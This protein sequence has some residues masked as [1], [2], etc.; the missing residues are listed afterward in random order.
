MQITPGNIM[1]I[2][3]ILLLFSVLAGRIGT[4]YGV[5]VLVLF[6][7]IGMAAG[8]D[9]FGIQ[10]D[11]AAVAELIG[12]FSLCI[13]LFSGG[14]DT[15]FKKV[16]P[17]MGPGLVLATF[18]VLLTTALTGVF[19]HEMMR[20]LLPEYAF[21]WIESF[22]LAAIMSSTDSASVFSILN[23]SG[24]GLKQRLKP[25]LELE[26]GSNDP[27]AYLMVILFISII[28]DGTTLSGG[29]I[30]KTSLEL[31]LQL[32]IGI[33]AGFIIGKVTV[34]LVN[35]LKS[36]NEFLY[37]VMVIACCF[38]AF[39]LTGLI[40]GNSYLAVY[41]AGLVVGNNKLALKRTI[42]TFFGGFTWLVQI[43]MFLTLGLLVNPHELLNI[44][45]PGLLLGIF[46]I[47]VS[48]PVS[49]YL[50]LAPFKRYT[51]KAK[52]YIGWVGLRGA[53]PIIFA[54]YA[55]M[56]PEVTHARFMFNLVFFITLL[57]LLIQG[58]T[59]NSMAKWFGLTE[60][61]PTRH[62]DFELPEEITAVTKEMT[63]TAEHLSEG[64]RLCEM[65]IPDETLVILIKRDDTYLVPKG[66]TR[67]YI[68]DT[69]L[70]L[71]RENEPLKK[72]LDRHCNC[73]SETS[74]AS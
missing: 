15:D 14:L 52:T 74:T 1:L 64:S 59:V 47:L 58:T 26:S 54:T 21:G 3:A 46:M 16:K 13:I 37:P 20:L 12:M 69:I 68:G 32:A 73:P 42:S 60:E 38:F 7:G 24:I 70:L 71:G 36:D 8:V 28:E 55:L 4:K 66:N 23:S 57:S 62:F 39:T 56:S 31:L 25:T 27:M 72:I 49:V 6:L 44:I 18:G 45:F 50:C 65:D 30:F 5:P 11:N 22:L 67:L 29:M 53:V 33:A 19:I 35:I 2:L 41:I 61:L 34:K 48:R 51:L 63:I 40:K 10:F 43:L 9:G 17:I